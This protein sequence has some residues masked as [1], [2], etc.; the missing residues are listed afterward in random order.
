MIAVQDQGFGGHKTVPFH[1][2]KT[3]ADHEIVEIYHLV[4]V[5]HEPGEELEGG[6]EGR[7]ETPHWSFGV[8]VGGV[9]EEGWHVDTCFCCFVEPGIKNLVSAKI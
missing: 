7:L 5:F 8:G 2:R 6:G 3:L 1:A 4:G 9:G